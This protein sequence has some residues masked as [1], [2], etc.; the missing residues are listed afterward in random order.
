MDLS[1]WQYRRMLGLWLVVMLMPGA[2]M[3]GEVV[4][5]SPGT[6][7][8]SANVV[9]TVHEGLLSLRAQD[10]SLKAIFEALGRQLSIEVVTHI[11]ADERITIAFDQL[12]FMEAL[13]RFR[14]SVNSLVLEE[15]AK[16]RG[17]TRKLV[18]V[19]KR[20]AGGPWHPT[21]PHSDRPLA[22]T[23]AGSRQPAPFTFQFDPSVV[24]E[25]G[26]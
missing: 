11:P 24:E 16:D 9:L 2:L 21:M 5:P 19:S 6:S 4:H 25:R 1:T 18:V 14:P 13:R 3:A 26:S 17:T 7:E 10:A 8:M 15:A 20:L 23:P 22:S 12:S